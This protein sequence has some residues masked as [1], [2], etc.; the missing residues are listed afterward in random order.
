MY[1]DNNNL[2]GELP[3]QLGNL[4]ILEQ[5]SFWDNNLT[6]ADSYE[7]GIL[8]DTVA[9]VALYES[10]NGDEW[11][12]D[13]GSSRLYSAKSRNWLSYKPLR[14]WY[15]VTTSGGRVTELFLSKNKV[16]RGFSGKIPPALGL[17]NGLRKLDLSENPDLTGCIP[18]SLRD[19]E[20][21]GD[22]PFC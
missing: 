3:S 21:Q 10:A 19:V 4:S 14:E 5:V 7:N 1:L 12:I 6:W 8:A 22:L 17:L 15:G 13:V 16:R 11:A 20:Y 18:S 2:S 9:L